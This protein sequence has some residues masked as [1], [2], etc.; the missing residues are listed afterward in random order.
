MT[1]DSSTGGYLAPTS[2]AP[3]EDAALDAILQG[4]VVGVTGLP[5]PLVRPRWQPIPP[6]QPASTTDWCA[7]GV[8]DED[9]EPTVAISHIGRD[10]SG[11]NPNGYSKSISWMTITVLASFYGP[12]ARGNAALLR[13]GLVIAQNRESLFGLDIALVERPG[14]ATFVP[15]IINEQTIR[16]V[17]I[18]MRFRRAIT[19]TWAID[20]LL[21]AQMQIE[22]DHPAADQSFITPSSTN[23][24]EP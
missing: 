12:N 24:P 22:T 19:R 16:R 21:D 17:D 3:S 8:V 9:P 11:N 23:P 20:D 4:L 13:D 15:E 18:D 5:G 1:N 10:T 14:K 7:I 6:Q 2:A